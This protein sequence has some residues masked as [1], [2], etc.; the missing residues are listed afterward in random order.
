[1]IYA[2]ALYLFCIAISKISAVNYNREIKQKNL[3]WDPILT[4]KNT[5]EKKLTIAFV[6]TAGTIQNN[7]YTSKNNRISLRV[8]GQ[9]PQFSTH[10]LKSSIEQCDN[11]NKPNL[12]ISVKPNLRAH[13]LSHAKI[14]EKSA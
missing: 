8:I 11:Y 10:R 6:K 7:N 13:P 4:P 3:N 14:A 1:M 2:L 9:Q 5:K 12:K